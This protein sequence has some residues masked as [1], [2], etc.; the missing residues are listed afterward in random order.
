MTRFSL[1][2][3]AAAIVG[4][5]GFTQTSSPALACAGSAGANGLEA[6]PA[7]TA[8][9]FAGSY[10]RFVHDNGAPIF[11][12]GGSI[13]ISPTQPGE[14]S[15]GVVRVWDF[16]SSTDAQSQV[17]IGAAGSDACPD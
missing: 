2:I 16:D 13:N 3:A 14:N 9:T 11:W 8:G 15:E 5:A 7:F 17:F 4:F 10:D 12:E 6:S 1:L